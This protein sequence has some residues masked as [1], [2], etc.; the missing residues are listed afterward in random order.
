MRLK[1]LYSLSFIIL[2][3]FHSSWAATKEELFIEVNNGQTANLGLIKDGQGTVTEETILT[4]SSKPFVFKQFSWTLVGDKGKLKMNYKYQLKDKILSQGNSIQIWNPEFKVN[5]VGNDI[6]EID[7]PSNDTHWLTF[8]PLGYGVSFAG[9]TLTEFETFLFSNAGSIES[10][11][12]EITNGKR[13]IVLTRVMSDSNYMTFWIDPAQGYCIVKEKARFNENPP[14]FIGEYSYKKYPV[15]GT[16]QAIWYPTV[17]KTTSFD[18]KG[19]ITE[20]MTRL[21][22]NTRFNLSLPESEADEKWKPGAMLKDLRTNPPNV[23]T[24]KNPATTAEI[25]N[26]QE[27]KVALT[28]GKDSITVTTLPN[29]QTVITKGIPDTQNTK[30]KNNNT[31]FWIIGGILVISGLLGGYILRKRKKTA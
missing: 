9:M 8:K 16:S 6:V 31:L 17:I 24:I 1:I 23:C 7:N 12:E 4:D 15:A 13:M 22:T 28:P 30:T 3:V 20:K 21:F 10:I 2:F 27:A 29:G 25:L 26:G 19:N 14:H 11:K 5:N 18:E